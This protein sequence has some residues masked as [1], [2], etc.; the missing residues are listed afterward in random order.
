MI[1]A[2]IEVLLKLGGF[3]LPPDV[4]TRSPRFWDAIRLRVVA[5]AAFIGVVILSLSAYGFLPWVDG[6]A[7]TK[8]LQ[9]VLTAIH[10][11][12]ADEIQSQIFELRVRECATKV[13][14]LRLELTQRMQPLEQKYFELTGQPYV[15]VQCGDL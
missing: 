10:A 1:G 12:Q 11:T 9:E 7:R 6:F 15:L 3:I 5:C 8:S 14:D 13:D 4:D 2:I